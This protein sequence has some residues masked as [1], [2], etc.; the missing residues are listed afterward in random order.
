[1]LLLLLCNVR[2]LPSVSCCVPHANNAPRN[3]RR[4]K[5]LNFFSRY[6]KCRIAEDEKLI[7]VG[8]DETHGNMIKSCIQLRMILVYYVRPPK[9]LFRLSVCLSVCAFVCQE[10]AYTRWV[11]HGNKLLWISSPDICRSSTLFQL[12]TR[13]TICNKMIIKLNRSHDLKNMWSW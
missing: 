8:T 10:I 11:K 5:L 9:A 4:E 12:Q 1:M 7:S 6:A 3:A 2:R 13:Q